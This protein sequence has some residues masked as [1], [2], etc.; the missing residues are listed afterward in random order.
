M[1]ECVKGFKDIDVTDI[2]NKY[3]EGTIS[4]DIRFR[5]IAPNEGGYIELIIDI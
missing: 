4:Y 2:E 3:I 1:K 5:A